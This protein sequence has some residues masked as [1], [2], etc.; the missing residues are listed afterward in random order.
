MLKVIRDGIDFLSLCS[1]IGQENM[2]QPLN[3]SD[4]KL[5]PIATW[6]FAFSRALG[7]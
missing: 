4:A 2:C 6:P 7:R 5:K 3:Q 1:V